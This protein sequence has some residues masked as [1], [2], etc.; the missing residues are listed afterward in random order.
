MTWL[1][2]AAAIF[3]TFGV[4]GTITSVG[5]PREPLTGGTAAA[6]TIISAGIITLLI[7]A[8]L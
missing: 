2:Y 5:K 6:S 7:L 3:L 8:T 4:I 1:Y